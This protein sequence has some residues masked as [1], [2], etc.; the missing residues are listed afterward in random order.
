VTGEPT[1][2]ATGATS[3][4]LIEG[5]AARE[6]LALAPAW[7][8]NMK[9][10]REVDGRIIL[11]GETPD[12]CYLWVQPKAWSAMTNRGDDA[13]TPNFGVQMQ[14]L[15]Q[16][17]GRLETNDSEFGSLIGADHRNPMPTGPTTDVGHLLFPA[18]VLA[19]GLVVMALIIRFKRKAG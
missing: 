15:A 10:R 19:A 13:R 18:L 2:G 7:A 3:A 6:I 16:H 17:Q 11:V 5:D 4:V 8:R 1:T 14:G 9:P 12:G